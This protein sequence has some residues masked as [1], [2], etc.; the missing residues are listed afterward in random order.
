MLKII[1]LLFSCFIFDSEVLGGLFQITFLSQSLDMLLSFI[2]GSIQEN[3]LTAAV[4][5]YSNA[6]T[7]KSKILFDNKGKTGIYQWT[8]KGSGKIYIG[9]AVDLSKRLKK[10]YFSS[11]LKR[12]DNYISRALT[13]HG[14][15]VFSLTILEFID[16]SNSNIKNA[17]KI[18]LER[19]QY[20]IDSLLPGYN[21]NPIAGSRL[22]SLHSEETKALISEAMSGEN[23]PLFGKTRS[24]ETKA[25]ISEARKGKTYS[26]ETKTLMS[27]AHK[28]K[29]KSE[30]TKQKMSEAKSG[31]NH[32]NFGKSLSAE[33]KAKLRE[34]NLGKSLS[35]ETKVKLSITKGGGS[36]FV[37]NTHGLLVNNFSS[38]RETAKFFN[39]CHKTIKRYS[40]NGKLFK[41]QWVLSTFK[42]TPASSSEETSD[43][44]PLTMDVSNK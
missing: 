6:E 35:T 23:H 13:L 1:I 18:I 5:V 26:A 14:Y 19:E 20:Y 15:S 17:R 4:I 25:L 21:L 43:S 39:C 2:P 16:I 37:Y 3:L 28:G 44:T 40:I 42:N 27:E 30:E 36:I 10:Y 38:A 31:E 22:G 9:S 41:E 32:P 24:I 7:D 12:M 34:V 8:H 11:E 29:V 33:I